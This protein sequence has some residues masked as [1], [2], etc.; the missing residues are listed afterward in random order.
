MSELQS[1]EKITGTYSHGTLR[2]NDL[3]AACIE[4]A[5][6]LSACAELSA[7]DR[8]ENRAIMEDLKRTDPEDLDAA[9]WPLEMAWYNLRTPEGHYVGMLEGDASD[10]GIWPEPPDWT[11]D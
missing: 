5:Q 2:V 10:L 9:M 7:D 4:I 6:A 1:I 3:M 11:E 8:A